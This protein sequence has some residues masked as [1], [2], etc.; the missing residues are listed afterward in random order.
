MIRCQPLHRDGGHR[1]L[2]FGDDAECPGNIVDTNQYVVAMG[3]AAVLIDPGG[4]EIFPAMLSALGDAMA[5]D[6]VRHVVLS[7]QDPDIGSSLPLWREVCRPD[8]KV[9]ISWLWTSFV[10]HFDADATFQPVPDAGATIDLAGLPLRLV[11]AHFLHSPGNFHVY[12]ERAGI[13]FSA[14]VAASLVPRDGR[15]GMFVTDFAAH[16]R[17]MEG[18]HRRAMG[19]ERARDAWLERVSRLDVKMLAPQHGLILKGDDVKRFYDWFAGLE[20]GEGIAV[21]G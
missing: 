6:D 14:D 21:G 5:V 10:S 3:D 17:H 8:L 12:D 7:H 19:S 15:D 9:H 4:A 20:I 16:I 18:W 13:L 11:P 1:W 2:V